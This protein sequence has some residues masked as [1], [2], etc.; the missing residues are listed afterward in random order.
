MRI[1]LSELR[2]LAAQAFYI[3]S[4]IALIP[5][6][7]LNVERFADVL[8]AKIVDEEHDNVWLLWLEA[9]DGLGLAT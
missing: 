2:A 1:G 7:S 6:S 5:I 3:G 9:A 4:L 8:P